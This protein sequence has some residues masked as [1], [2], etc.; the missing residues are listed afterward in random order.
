MISEVRGALGECELPGLSPSAP[1]NPGF[2]EVA[3]LPSR[4]RGVLWILSKFLQAAL[5]GVSG[6]LPVWV[7]ISL[8]SL[9]RT[10]G[11]LISTVDPQT[12]TLGAWF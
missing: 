7:R 12:L 6:L 3:L 5:T 2:I 9:V 1:S 10:T 4:V 11:K 8:V